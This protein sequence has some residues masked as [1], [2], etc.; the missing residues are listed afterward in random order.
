MQVASR[1]H[2]FTDFMEWVQGQDAFQAVID[3]M[4]VAR[5]SP[6]EGSDATSGPHGAFDWDKVRAVHACWEREHPNTRLLI[7]VSAHFMVGACMAKPEVRAYI[8]EQQAKGNLYAAPC[9]GACLRWYCAFA[10]IK[11]GFFCRLITNADVNAHCERILTKPQLLR[12]WSELHCIR[13]YFRG[14]DAKFVFPRQYTSCTQQLQNGAW[15]FPVADSDRWLLVKPVDAL[16]TSW[17]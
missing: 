12:R 5:Y 6:P 7:V 13:Y 16:A 8:Q 2:K 3:A 10:A 14:R 11:G 9:A 15:M 17:R 1:A 4:S